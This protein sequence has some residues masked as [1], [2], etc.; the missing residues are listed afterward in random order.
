M[1]P[2]QAQLANRFMLGEDARAKR[3]SAFARIAAAVAALVGRRNRPDDDIASRYEGHAWC[4]SAEH[5]LSNDVAT[6]R[7]P[8]F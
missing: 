8:R 3:A 7:R 5:R 4:D 1:Q 2:F 6:W